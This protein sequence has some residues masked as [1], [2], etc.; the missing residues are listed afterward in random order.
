MSAWIVSREH[1]DTLVTAAVALKIV[2]D[3]E[4]DRGILGGTGSAMD[5]AGQLLWS[6]NLESVAYRYPNDTGNGDRPGPC[7]FTDDQAGAYTFTARPTEDLAVIA[8]AAACLDYQSCE[9]PGWNLS[10]ARAI[11]GDILEAIATRTGLAPDLLNN[12]PGYDAAPWGIDETNA[13]AAAGRRAA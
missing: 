5:R 13:P 3:D 4:T 2:G 8:K 12:L 1:I 7:S 10:L 9:H 6:E 11:V